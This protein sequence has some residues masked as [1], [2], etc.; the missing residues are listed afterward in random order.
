MCNKLQP[1]INQ[2]ISFVRFAHPGL[3]AG[4]LQQV[5]YSG[6]TV[7]SY[8]LYSINYSFKGFTSDI[9]IDKV[10]N[11]FLIMLDSIVAPERGLFAERFA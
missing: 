10:I 5:R 1:H 8:N 9:A 3:S 7:T 4:L 2:K 6:F 11:S